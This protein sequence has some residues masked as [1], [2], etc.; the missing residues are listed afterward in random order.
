MRVLILSCDT[1]GG[2]NSCAAALR[3]TFGAEGVPCAVKDSLRFISP[4]VSKLISKGHSWI[5][6]NLPALFSAGYEGSEKYPRLYMPG[7]AAY[8]F[9]CSGAERLR[10]FIAGFGAG[11]LIC[12]HVFSALAV[13]EVFRRYGRNL[14]AYFVCTDYT[15]SPGCAQSELDAY[16]IPDTALAE[17]FA[18]CGVPSEKLIPS[19]I[20][21]RGEFRPPASKT[22]AKHRLGFGAYTPHILIMSG[23]MGC[24]PI[25][26]L[27]RAIANSPRA[28]FRVSVVCG[29]NKALK[30]RLDREY[31]G[32]HRIIIYGYTQEIPA[33]MASADLLLTKP[34]GMSTTEG[35]KM[36]LPMLLLDSVAGCEK[37]NMRYFIERGVAMM[38]PAPE[39]AALRAL[40]LLYE[41]KRIASMADNYRRMPENN[42]SEIIARHVLGAA[43]GGSGNKVRT[44]CR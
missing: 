31:A 8:H 24:G 9:L 40:T 36:R 5:Y 23:S 15:C 29:T 18:G 6:R 42:A 43:E 4:A 37:R 2:H 39:D 35:A 30:R 16:F 28:D 22:D 27:V 34:G 11:A 25:S 44:A 12:T 33:L 20:P 41:P 1:G 14:P 19:G 13:S 10:D 38:C 17:E 26:S 7:G 21:V 3:S 32:D